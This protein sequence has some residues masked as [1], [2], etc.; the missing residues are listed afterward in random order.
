MKIWK[1]N[2]QNQYLF[3]KAVL[4]NLLSYTY[5]IKETT[6]YKRGR[7]KYS[8]RWVLPVVQA[9][10]PRSSPSQL[11]SAVRIKP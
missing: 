6:F 7:R 4:G 10:L 1:G 3:G 2:V 11:Q 8:S 9:T 5:W